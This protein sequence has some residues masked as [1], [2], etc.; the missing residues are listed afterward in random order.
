MD[1]LY[2]DDMRYLDLME[3]AMKDL[4][5]MKS[6]WAKKYPNVIVNLWSNVDGSK[7][8]GIMMCA[9]HKVDLNADTLGEL[10]AQGEMFLR[11]ISK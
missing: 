11:K 8:H 7:F 2:R 6:Y 9:D 3:S 10:I 5:E 1:I 4:D